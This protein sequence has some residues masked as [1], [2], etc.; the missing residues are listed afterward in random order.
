[1]LELPIKF[2]SFLNLKKTNPE[3]ILKLMRYDKKNSEGRIK[4]VLIKNYGEIL[5]DVIADNKSIKQSLKRTE[6][7]WFKR[8]TAGL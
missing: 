4:F 3:V 7:I 8:A 2:L 6:Q 1:M 5:V